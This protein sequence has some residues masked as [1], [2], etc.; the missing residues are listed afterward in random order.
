MKKLLALVTAASLLLGSPVFAKGRGSGKSTAKRSS[1]SV[2][3]KRVHVEELYAQG[4]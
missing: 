3:P 1:S 2:N 4:R